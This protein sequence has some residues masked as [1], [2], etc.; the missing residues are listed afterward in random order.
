MFSGNIIDHVG[1]DDGSRRVLGGLVLRCAETGEE[2]R[3]EVVDHGTEAL[4]FVQPR[5][6]FGGELGASAGIESEVAPA[7]ASHAFAAVHNVVQSRDRAGLVCFGLG[8]VGSGW[9]G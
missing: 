3:G 6:V 2:G 8:R 7:R 1:G 5:E 4:V 9:V